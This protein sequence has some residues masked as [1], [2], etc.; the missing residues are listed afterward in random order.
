MLKLS[1]D[2]NIGNF[3]LQEIKTEFSG[4]QFDLEGNTN[5]IL[6]KPK[7]MKE[8]IDD[9]LKNLDIISQK[10]DFLKKTTNQAGIFKEI[11][12][13]EKEI[14]IMKNQLNL[15]LKMMTKLE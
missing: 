9:Y 10:L 11:G 15:D 1:Q 13:L 4:L 2:V 14:A 7:E 8:K 5:S 6:M 12:S 3:D